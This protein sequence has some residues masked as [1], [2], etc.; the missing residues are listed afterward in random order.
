MLL[1]TLPIIER[2]TSQPN[3]W[4]WTGV[5]IILIIISLI[6]SISVHKKKY[7]LLISNLK[8]S[9]SRIMNYDK[10]QTEVWANILIWIIIILCYG[11]TASAMSQYFRI[12][13]GFNLITLLLL[14]LGAG[15]YL[16]IKYGVIKFCGFIFKLQDKA[17]TFI[18]TY[19]VLISLL[20][21]LCFPIS[22]GIIY[23]TEIVQKI[24]IILFVLS[25]IIVF[26]MVCI[27]LFQIFFRGIGSIFYIFLYLCAMEILPVFILLKIAFMG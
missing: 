27:K 17:T 1:E 12:T 10:E 18:N 19:F 26:N 14:S 11:L 15:I 9:R 13:E 25:G 20:G 24:S 7:K 8:N 21:I 3:T 4:P 23:G 6:T 5:I 2:N 16:L 22:I